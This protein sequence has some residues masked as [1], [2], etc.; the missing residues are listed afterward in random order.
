MADLREI[1]KLSDEEKAFLWASIR[2]REED[3]KEQQAKMK[4]NRKGRR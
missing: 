1:P 3:E 4:A 2:V